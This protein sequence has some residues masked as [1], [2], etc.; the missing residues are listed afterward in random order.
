MF[1]EEK[2]L[3]DIR[4]MMSNWN[5]RLELDNSNGLYNL[6][7]L[8]ENFCRDILNEIYEDNNIKLKNVNLFKSNVPAIDLAD[9]KGEI[10]I[11]ITTQD[12]KQ[13]VENTVKQFVDYNYNLHYKKLIIIILKL[14]NDFK[15]KDITYKDYKFESQNVLSLENI[16][17]LISDLTPQKISKIKEYMFGEEQKITNL[18]KINEVKGKLRENK[19]I[20]KPIIN[21]ILY[22]VNNDKEDRLWSSNNYTIKEILKNNKQIIITGDAASGKTTFLKNITDDINEN[23][24]F[25]ALFKELKYYCNQ[26]IEEYVLKN[27]SFVDSDRLVLLLDGL[28]EIEEKYR[29][30]FLKKLIDFCNNNQS[31]KIILSCRSN[32]YSSI[33]KLEYFQEYMLYNFQ[34][35]D[36]KQYFKNNNLNYDKMLNDIK[37]KDYGFLLY[38]PFYLGEICENFKNNGYLPEKKSILENAI[39]NIYNED[40]NKYKLNFEKDIEKI[41]KKQKEIVQK[42]GFILECQGKNCISDLDLK[43]LFPREYKYLKYCGLLKKDN[44]DWSFI[45]NNFGEYLASKELKRY[46]W[47]EIKKIVLLK[48]S[49]LIKPT[50]YNTIVFYLSNNSNEKMEDLI[51]KYNEKLIFYIEK[52]KVSDSKKMIIFKKIIDY[53]MNK[54]IWIP[55]DFSSNKKFAEFFSTKDVYDYLC[56]IIIE[57]K[58]YVKTHNAINILIEMVYFIKNHNLKEILENVIVSNNYN[59]YIKKNA[60]YIL[61]NADYG[62]REFIIDIM[63]KLKE[64][65]NQYLRTGYFYYINKMNLVDSMIEVILD[66]KNIIGKKFRVTKNDENYDDEEPTLIDEYTEFSL[67]FRNIHLTSTVLKII[68]YLEKNNNY[69]FFN[70]DI[71]KNLSFS[72]EHLNDSDDK[73][74]ELLFKLYFVFSKKYDRNALISILDII[75]KKGL[76]IN[77]FKK[78]LDNPKD[79]YKYDLYLVTNEECISFFSKEYRIGKYNDE[80]GMLMLSTISPKSSEYNNIKNIYELNTKKTV[81][82]PYCPLTD[83][84]KNKM[85][86]R[87]FDSLF[88]KEQFKSMIEYF[89]DICQKQIVDLNNLY[90]IELENNLWDNVLFQKIRNFL[91]HNKMQ[92]FQIL[93]KNKINDYINEFDWNYLIISEVYNI[94][95]NDESVTI[96]NEQLEVIEKCCIIFLK[97]VNFNAAYSNIEKGRCSV[98][99]NCIILAVLRRKLN[100]KYPKKIL[101]DMLLFE[102]FHDYEKKGIKSIIKEV[103]FEDCKNRI[104]YNFQNKKLYD[105]TLE[106]YLDFF[107][108]NHIY[109]NIDIVYKYF[110]S[111][112]ILPNVKIKC[113]QYILS[114]GNKKI[115]HMIFKRINSFDNEMYSYLISFFNNNEKLALKYLLPIYKKIENEELK[116]TMQKILMKN[117]IYKGFKEYYKYMKK[118]NKSYSMDLNSSTLGADKLF[119]I[120][121]LFKMLQLTTNKEFKDVRFDSLYSN[122]IKTIEQIGKKSQFNKNI[123]ILSTKIFII[124]NR[125][126][127]DIGFL[128]YIIKNLNTVDIN[129]ECM[130]LEDVKKILKG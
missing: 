19:L 129:Q 34:E 32:F 55:Y 83:E 56:N 105:S 1:D 97:K 48:N 98:N 121:I 47:K 128:N 112:D 127:E 104:I 119:M 74:E 35:N 22:K 49:K 57:N 59:K 40:K 70:E 66:Y 9:F 64:E 130:T 78:I 4:N 88:D 116:M 62:D 124:K 36:V 3:I 41:Q 61:A 84:E 100:L 54:K 117:S 28:D 85:A 107:I 113:F 33:S 27:Y 91:V 99:I 39:A 94:I 14:K 31:I 53:Y 11:Q 7:I 52:D 92:K 82:V 93:E 65:E 87:Y 21:R 29:K 76:R 30:D 90:D 101:L 50:W 106:F 114:S 102:P 123:I 122:L 108:E 72:I 24:Y 95:D 23:D 38:N 109:S 67:I 15:I 103:G 120:L 63:K 42:L 10:A 126:Y 125:K 18:K 77:L 37:S 8:S 68:N 80:I 6:N 51:L 16:Y 86:Q 60:F 115:I 5:S 69:G 43:S 45:H 44:D 79:K 20:S 46:S 26:S 110:N 58:H 71:I 17:Q 75:E 12:S 25:L 118:S 13:K 111:S 73:K 81:K 89:F 2:D 96:H